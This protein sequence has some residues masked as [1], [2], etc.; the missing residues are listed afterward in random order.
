VSNALI[1]LP[2]MDLGGL[3]MQIDPRTRIGMRHTDLTVLTRE[4]KLVG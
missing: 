3:R 1:N 4:G 2:A